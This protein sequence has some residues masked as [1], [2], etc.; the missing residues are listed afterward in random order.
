MGSKHRVVAGSNRLRSDRR[1]FARRRTDSFD[2]GL[3]LRDSSALTFGTC[4]A[5]VA[6]LSLT[7]CI[8]YVK[9]ELPAAPDVRAPADATKLSATYELSLD[10]IPIA[11]QGQPT[12]WIELE[13]G[14][15]PPFQPGT[16]GVQPWTVDACRAA[17]HDVLT[18]SGYFSSVDES[19]ERGDVHFKITTAVHS[20]SFLGMSPGV[21]TAFVIVLPAWAADE[22]LYHVEVLQNERDRRSYD[23]KATVMTLGWTPLMLAAPFGERA[24]SRNARIYH[25]VFGKVLARMKTDGAFRLASSVP[26]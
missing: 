24:D 1:A 9:G 18:S 14:A 21:W 3:Q 17:L 6:A 8:Q 7:S 23:A 4:S 19:V 16:A 25:A 12:Q 10:Q 15:F 22:R 2:R 26:Q 5:L 11:D 20:T 13:Q